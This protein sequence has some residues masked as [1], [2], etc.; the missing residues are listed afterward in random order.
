M[1]T[2]NNNGCMNMIVSKRKYCSHKCY[3]VMI[4]KNPLVENRFC[5]RIDCT[6]ILNKKQKNFCSN[7]CAYEDKKGKASW[8]K[9]LTKYD[10]NRIKTNRLGQHHSEGTK[11]KI[12]EANIGKTAWNK[13]KTDIYSEETLNKI[14]EARAKQTFSEE[15][16]NKKSE[17]MKKQWAD[18]IIK[19][20]RIK[21]AYFKKGKEHPDWIDGSSF[22][23]YGIEFNKKFKK[24][25]KD[26]DFNVCQTPGCINTEGLCVHHIDYDKKNNNPE[27]LITL[28]RSCHSKTNDR[29]KRQY[30]TE[31]YNNIL[32][33]YL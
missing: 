13:G 11:Q 17:T 12:R 15:S 33:I 27:N 6:N 29:N 25:I 9:G 7:F 4:R 14:R 1:N 16:I 22:E 32:T 5:K 3:W 2:C 26:R 18:P 23:P 8:N 19:E 20:K 31:Y 24:L 21:N 10:D 28:C 30:F